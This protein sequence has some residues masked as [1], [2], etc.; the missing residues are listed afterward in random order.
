[1]LCASVST[2]RGKRCSLTTVFHASKA[3]MDHGLSTRRHSEVNFGCRCWKRLSPSCVGHTIRWHRG[4]SRMVCSCSAVLHA[5]RSILTYA[6]EKRNP[7]DCCLTK[8]H[9]PQERYDPQRAPVDHDLL[10]AQLLSF[11]EAGYP[12]GATIGATDPA[13]E[14]SLGLIGN[15]AYS[16]MD[17]YAEDGLQLVRLRNPWGMTSWTGKWRDTC[18]LWTEKLREKM[19]AYGNDSGFFWMSW[20]DFRAHFHVVD[21]CKH[22]RHLHELREQLVLP[23]ALTTSAPWSAL[24]LR[25]EECARFHVTAFQSGSHIAFEHKLLLLAR[26]LDAPLE[27][28][29]IVKSCTRRPTRHVFLE[30]QLEPDRIYTVLPVSFSAQ[31]QAQPAQRTLRLAVHSTTAFQTRMILGIPPSFIS[32]FLF[33]ET[34]VFGRTTPMFGSC[35]LRHQYDNQIVVEN[36]TK[37]WVALSTSLEGSQNIATSRNALSFSDTIPPLSAQLVVALSADQVSQ[38]T[39]VAL[40]FE[41]QLSPCKLA[42]K[43]Q[44]G[45]IHATMRI[46]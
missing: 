18:H 30:E 27:R 24:D 10:W 45:G 15:H 23:A 8:Y 38:P 6:L 3:Q 5:K 40:R 21:V 13:V 28:A 42:H 35:V 29:K 32:V 25:V 19:Q 46:W 43:S 4:R 12:M 17:M 16:I 9:V 20:A 39:M 34:K 1:M 31:R 26:P 2:A 41:H 33:N 22:S 14:A 37:G 36:Q 11:H 7:T 44:N